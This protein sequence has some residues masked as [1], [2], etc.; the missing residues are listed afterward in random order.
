MRCKGCFRSGGM[1]LLRR[2]SMLIKKDTNEQTVHTLLLLDIVWYLHV[3]SGTAAA[4]LL[5]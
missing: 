5:V 1:G 3:I 4:T 2:L